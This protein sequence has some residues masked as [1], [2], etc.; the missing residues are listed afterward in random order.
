MIM[1]KYLILIALILIQGCSSGGGD[2]AAPAVKVNLLGVWDYRF[3]FQNSNCDE[4][5]P[6]GTMTMESLNGDLTKLGNLLIQGQGI[7]TDSFGNCFFTVINEVDTKWSGRPAEQTASEFKAYVIADH[8]G[9]NTIKTY[10]LD[11]FTASKIQD[12][13]TSTNDVI[14][15]AALT[16]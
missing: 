2:D 9:D 15:T 8:L 1:K 14:E 11:S 3:Q 16:R 13:T 6:Q 12:T 7:D 4:L 10:T 5:F